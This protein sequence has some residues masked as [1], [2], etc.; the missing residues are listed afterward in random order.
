VVRDS[1]HESRY[2]I[3]THYKTIGGGFPEKQ[4]GTKRAPACPVLSPG[5]KLCNSRRL[6]C[7][8]AA[9]FLVC[10]KST[11]AEKKRLTRGGFIAETALGDSI[12]ACAFAGV[13][14]LRVCR[15]E[16]LRWDD[17]K[18]GAICLLKI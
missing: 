13:A 14:I 6:R 7:K 3:R 1:S 4:F 2:T 9:E 17:R 15:R 5:A 16:A 12:A 8:L 11:K 18:S 10:A